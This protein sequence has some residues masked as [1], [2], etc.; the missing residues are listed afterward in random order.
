MCFRTCRIRAP[1][2]V[3]LTARCSIG[4]P[5]CEN[6]A[7]N[8]WSVFSAA[9]ATLED[10]EIQRECVG[11]Q[12]PGRRERL[13]DFCLADLAE[14]AVADPSAT[15]TRRWSDAQGRIPQTKRNG[16]TR[17]SAMDRARRS[18]GICDPWRAIH[19]DLAYPQP[20]QRPP[21]ASRNACNPCG[22]RFA[23]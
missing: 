9:G 23:Q 11:R 2:R 17:A 8:R 13:L 1:K 19:T 10:P 7:I 22:P 20:D 14:S 4:A 21:R 5:G 15:R 6:G 12:D 16:S 3:A 18:V